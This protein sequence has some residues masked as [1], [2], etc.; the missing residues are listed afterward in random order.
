VYPSCGPQTP[1]D[2]KTN[3]DHPSCT[4]P[5]PPIDCKANPNDA[6]CTQPVD[7]TKTPNDPS[8]KPDCTKT[9][10]ANHAKLIVKLLSSI[11][12]V[13][14][15]CNRYIMSSSCYPLCPPPIHIDCPE[16]VGST[17]RAIENGKCVYDPIKCKSDEHLENGKCVK[18]G[19]DEECAFNPSLPNAR[20]PATKITS[21]NVL[22]VFQ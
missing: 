17:L 15:S 13:S 7:C 19:P 6:S 9:Q 20:L 2:C 8:C 4:Q 5:A 21:A 22:K 1:S 11:T 3:P 18:N 16:K 10:I 12:A 14:I